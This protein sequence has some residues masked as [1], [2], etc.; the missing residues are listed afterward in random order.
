MS[1]DGWQT[2]S[3]ASVVWWLLNPSHAR[4]TW[5]NCRVAEY[6]LR[7]VNVCHNCFEL[8]LLLLLK[9]FILHGRGMAVEDICAVAPWCLPVISFVFICGMVPIFLNNSLCI[10]SFVSMIDIGW[11]GLAQ[12]LLPERPAVYPYSAALWTIAWRSLLSHSNQLCL[13][14]SK[15]L[16]CCSPGVWSF[17]ML[18]Y[19]RCNSWD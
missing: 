19:A 4:W 12:C 16:L 14:K 6:F 7:W 2:W 3:S 8:I 10:E 17:M 1:W 5:F 18:H 13:F 11:F 9:D 15:I